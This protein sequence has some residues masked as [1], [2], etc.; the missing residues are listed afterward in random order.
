MDIR[1]ATIEDLSAISAIEDEC[2]SA[3]NAVSA[4]VLE[5]RLRCFGDHFWIMSDGGRVVG[6]VDGFVTD[7]PDIT[8]DMYEIPE[9]HN[10]SGRWQMLFGVATSP[11]YRGR[12]I[13]SELI[14]RVIEDSK[15]QGRAGLVLAC[16]DELVDFYARFGFVNEGI[17]NKTYH[18]GS[19]W[20]QMR[21]CLNTDNSVFGRK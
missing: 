16:K 10:E 12:G 4:E 7:E 17:S 1:T 3:E 11:E 2:F 19:E 9:L 6:F 18:G 20:N 5:K 14:R 13:A 21:M 15:A 8:D